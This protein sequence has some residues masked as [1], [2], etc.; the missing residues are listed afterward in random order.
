MEAVVIL[1]LHG[2]MGAGKNEAAKRLGRLSGAL[3]V[4]E[5]SFAA[6]LKRS[7]AAALGVTV[8]DLERWKNDPEAWILVD[9]GGT[10]RSTQTVRS[11][12]QRY[13]T[14]AHRDVFGASF[15][16]DAAMP[17]DGAYDDALYVVTDVR[18]ANEAARVRFLGGYVVLIQ[19]ANSDT[20]SHPSEALLDQE[21]ADFI[22]DNSRRDDGFAS[23]DRQLV[24]ILTEI[25]KREEWAA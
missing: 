15:W 21:E 24:G 11:F 20:G 6:A 18:F 4:V 19:G 9:V 3:P 14:E 7:A 10:H 2:K 1:G 23:L 13:G 8:D 25:A 22:I 12:L 17:A 5:V 16:L